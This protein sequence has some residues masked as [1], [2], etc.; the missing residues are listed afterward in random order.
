MKKLLL[1][2]LICVAL[3][4]LGL[5]P[6][7][8]ISQPL[9]PT[10]VA[11][12]SSTFTLTVNG[13]GFISGTI[14]KWNGA[15]RPTTFVSASR[16]TVQISSTDVAQA[17]TNSVSV[18][19]PGPGGGSSNVA[20]FTVT[21]P[22]TGIAL[23]R[24]GVGAPQGAYSVVTGD[25]NHDGK[26]DTAV[27]GSSSKQISLV[28]SGNV[29]LQQY[30]LGLGLPSAHAM[31]VAIGD[32][33][34]DGNPDMVAAAGP[35][36]VLLG[37]G[38]GTFQSPVQYL[39]AS[40]SG[41]VVVRDINLDGTLDLVLGSQSNDGM[42]PVLLGNGDGT[43]R[44][45]TSYAGGAHVDSLVSDDF[46][47]DGI[48]DLALIPDQFSNQVCIKFGNGDGTFSPGP[49]AAIATVIPP[50][51][52]V[53]DFN[54]DG[55]PDLVLPGMVALGNGDGTFALTPTQFASGRV[56]SL[57]AADL[58][59]DGK[60]DLVFTDPRPAVGLNV[61]LGN[62][63][64]TL[65]SHFTVTFPSS[66][67]GIA[68]ADLDGD[69]RLDIVGTKQGALDLQAPA[70]TLSTKTLTFPTTIVGHESAPKTAIVTN[71]GSADLAISSITSNNAD[72][73]SSDD[74]PSVMAVGTFCTVSVIFKP[75]ILGLDLGA[76]TIKDNTAQGG[77]QT[78]KLHGRGK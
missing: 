29:A 24:S 61:L 20:W 39:P 41:Q 78:I 18:A 76:V 11:P 12:G 56:F 21:T 51:M 1:V 52:V 44:N 38:N 33:N 46:D 40:L 74:C 31:Q 70:V 8:A 53:A 60:E 16:V 77:S 36:W 67:H 54:G 55:K 9:S 75:S 32:F 27:L 6:A 65:G 45:G 68:V 26:A 2:I 19:N 10:S 71:T 57:T 73:L 4:A 3:P 63:N 13:V 28:V 34:N 66:T 25:F 14:V 15:T 23:K 48:S 72:Y 58:N 42:N 62:G 7:P 64:G 37:N 50:L 49:C 35:V 22:T 30:N 17:G 43:F 59:G 47:A 5:N 69:G